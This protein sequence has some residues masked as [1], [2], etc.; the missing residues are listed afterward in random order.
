MYVNKKIIFKI[1]LMLA[2]GIGLIF[3]SIYMPQIYC[4]TTWSELNSNIEAY[5]IEHDINTQK[6]CT[7]NLSVSTSS[8]IESGAYGISEAEY[9]V[10]R[11]Q[12]KIR[13]NMQCQ[14]ATMVIVYFVICYMSFSNNVVYKLRVKNDIGVKNEN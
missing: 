8:N 7:T 11:M 3:Y 1:I 4:D 6:A 9:E 10:Y 5:E 2:L 13:N 14:I 12:V